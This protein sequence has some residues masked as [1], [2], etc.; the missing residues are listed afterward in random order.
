MASNIASAD[1][2][3][4]LG[5]RQ[6]LQQLRIP[7]RVLPHEILFTPRLGNIMS[8]QQLCN[9]VDGLLD[10]LAHQYPTTV[11]P[12]P[13]VWKL[14]RDNVDVDLDKWDP[15]SLELDKALFITSIH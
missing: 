15:S 9:Y 6:E 1:P 2:P 5:R 4:A 14:V 12:Q 3:M 8:K 7:F 13:G 10:E 11:S